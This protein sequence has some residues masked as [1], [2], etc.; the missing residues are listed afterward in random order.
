MHW[1]C[2]GHLQT[3]YLSFLFQ[4]QEFWIPK[5]TPKNYKKAPKKTFKNTT[6]IAKYVAF[7]TWLKFLHGYCRCPWQISGFLYLYLWQISGMG[8]C[9]NLFSN[10]HSSLCIGAIGEA[11]LYRIPIRFFTANTTFLPVLCMCIYTTMETLD[12]VNI[13]RVAWHTPAKIQKC[14]LTNN[15]ERSCL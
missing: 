10:C 6:K 3:W 14:H 4:G 2:I 13:K 11:E 5:F 8:I 1:H 12:R 9:C 15:I 7:C